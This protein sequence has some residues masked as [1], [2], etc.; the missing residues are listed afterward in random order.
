MLWAYE[1]SGPQPIYFFLFGRWVSA[2]AAA[3]LAALLDF[4]FRSTLPAVD[5]ALLLVTSRFVPRAIGITPFQ[6]SS[7][8]ICFGTFYHVRMIWD[9]DMGHSTLND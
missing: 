7:N 9:A 4:G 1:L 6:K 5:A 2:E 8:T 3:V